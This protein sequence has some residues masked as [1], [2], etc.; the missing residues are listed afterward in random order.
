MR[1]RSGNVVIENMVFDRYVAMGDK[2]S[3]SFKMF[4]GI[5]FVNRT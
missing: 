4:M 5:Y 3:L 2:E 1:A